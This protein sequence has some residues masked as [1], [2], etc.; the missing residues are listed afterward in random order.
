MRASVI[1]GNSGC[2]AAGAQPGPASIAKAAARFEGPRAE[3]GGS[4]Q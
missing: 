2:L 1:G 4:Q 3:G